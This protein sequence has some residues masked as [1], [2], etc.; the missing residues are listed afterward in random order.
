MGREASDLW[1]G[2]LQGMPVCDTLSGEDDNSTEGDPGLVGITV[3][4]SV[5]EPRPLF[6]L[7]NWQD[8]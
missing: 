7:P 3:P 5:A 1:F 8:H 4:G 2:D 6:P